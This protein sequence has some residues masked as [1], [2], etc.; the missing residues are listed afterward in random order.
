MKNTHII[1]IDTR[2]GDE[3]MMWDVAWYVK[4]V[5]YFFENATETPNFIQYN[6]LELAKKYCTT[7]CTL[8]W[9]MASLATRVRKDLTLPEREELIKL[10]MAESDFDP[11]I[12]WYTSRGV[13]VVRRWW[14]THNPENPIV[15]FSIYNSEDI[16]RKLFAKNFPVVTSFRGNSAFSK[17]AND[18]IVDGTSFWKTTFG[19]CRSMMWLTVYDNYK[20]KDW[21]RYSYKSVDQFYQVA[22]NGYERP[23]SFVFFLENEL[24]G[25]GKK[26]VDAMKKWLWNG[27]REN[28]NITRYESAIIAKRLWGTEVWNGSN[29]DKE[30]SKYEVSV[31]LNKAIGTPI[32]T[33]T[34]RNQSITRKE[35]IL[36][37]P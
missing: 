30:A 9:P 33:G 15:S 8:Y 26:L 21:R 22:E 25:D 20:S 37:L 4:D 1:D 2:T 28:D 24:S 5:N 7:L 32:Y 31:M 36:M 13:D 14:N 16:R 19:H 3:Y 34:D 18:G 23:Q 35:V 17:D 12:G 10:R 6:Q 11:K 27:E 29:P